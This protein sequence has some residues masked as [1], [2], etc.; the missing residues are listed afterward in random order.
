MEQSSLSDPTLVVPIE[1][2]VLV[3]GK[4]LSEGK[5]SDV[6][7]CSPAYSGGL[8]VAACDAVTHPRCGDACDVDLPLSDGLDA[9][10]LLSSSRTTSWYLRRMSRRSVLVKHSRKVLRLYTGCL[11]CSAQL[12]RPEAECGEG[13][14]TAWLEDAP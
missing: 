9:K 13:I 2:K 11:P 5:R 14:F 7:P 6:Q 3:D 12:D 4:W 8:I 10:S 1:R